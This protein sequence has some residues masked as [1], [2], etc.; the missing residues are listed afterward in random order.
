MTYRHGRPAFLAIVGGYFDARHPPGVPA[1]RSA[2]M[3]D[4]TLGWDHVDTPQIAFC[5]RYAYRDRRL[6]TESVWTHR[7][8]RWRP[9][10][11]VWPSLATSGSRWRVRAAC[12]RDA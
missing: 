8:N 1:D 12:H 6:S 10:K 9:S 11:L 4:I 7:R 3:T 5:A 2:F